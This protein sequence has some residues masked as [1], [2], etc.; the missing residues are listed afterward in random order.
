MMLVSV[1]F[2]F[3]HGIFVI[4][5]KIESKKFSCFLVLYYNIGAKI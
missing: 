3:V 4:W 2:R 5:V 1:W